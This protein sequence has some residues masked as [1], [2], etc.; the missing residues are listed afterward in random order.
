MRLHLEVCWRETELGTVT[1]HYSNTDHISSS[2][3]VH[4]K[5]TDVHPEMGTGAGCESKDS[6][7]LCC[8]KWQL[9]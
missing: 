8:V 7:S 2:G 1:T 6:L 5:Q 4:L 3:W 9:S